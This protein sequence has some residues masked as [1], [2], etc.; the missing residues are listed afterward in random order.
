MGSMQTGEESLDPQDWNQ[1]RALAHQMVDDILTYQKTVRRRP[2]WQR[3]PRYVEKRFEAHLPLKGQLERDVYRE[4]KRFI[5]PYPLGN[6]HPR[7]WGWVMGNG[8]PL[9]AL[10]E[11]LAAGM[12]PNVGGGNHVANLVERQV[13]DWLK[14]MI[15][16]SKKASGLLVSGGS[17]ANLTGLAVARNSKAGYDVRKNGLGGTRRRMVLYGSVEMHSSLTKAVEFLGLGRDALRCIPVDEAYRMDVDKLRIALESDLKSGE[18]PI[19]V[20]GTAGTT[21]TGSIDPL[22]ELA[23]IASEYSLWFH[24]DGAFGAFAYLPK[25]SRQLVRGMERAESIAFD[26]HKWGY[27]PFEVGC[28]LVSDAETHRR[29]F[30]LDAGYLKHGTRG[31]AGGP[32]WFSD[33][34]VQLTRGF[35]GLKVWMALKTY[36][37]RKLSRLVQQNIEQA[38]YLAGLIRKSNE[39]E[40]MAPVPLNVVCFRFK[41]AGFNDSRLNSLNQELLIRLQESGKAVVSGT[42]LKGRY[43]M[44]CAITNHRSVRND[45]NILVSEVQRIGNLLLKQSYS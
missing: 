14:E 6:I 26:L 20:I 35:R 7:F 15:G 31:T 37:V 13:I 42:E 25:K 9:G 3:V 41:K 5:L 22:K 1:L 43:V 16:Y 27:L 17:M 45:F 2:A 39:L 23:D 8:T 36:G 44:R 21:N 4:F 18:K 28:I 33:Y 29:T 40:L 30:A 10:S 38:S 11:M 12:N 19:C 34:G 32:I 24:I